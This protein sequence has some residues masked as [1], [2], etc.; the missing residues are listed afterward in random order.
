MHDDD[1]LV[2]DAMKVSMMEIMMTE[3]D[4]DQNLASWMVVQ[5]SMAGLLKASLMVSNNLRNPDNIDILGMITSITQ[6]LAFICDT[7]EGLN[8]GQR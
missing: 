3:S 6:I 1:L 8:N 7:T 5:A 4:I 2:T